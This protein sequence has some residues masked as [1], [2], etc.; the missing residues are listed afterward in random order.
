MKS[1]IF[2]DVC[3]INGKQSEQST[4]NKTRIDLLIPLTILALC[5]L[6][7]LGVII[8]LYYRLHKKSEANNYTRPE[9]VG[10][11]MELGRYI[12]LYFTCVLRCSDS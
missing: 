10:R 4:E 12:F 2:T 3:V 8:Y 1:R 11:A 9:G 5:L 6:F 7:S